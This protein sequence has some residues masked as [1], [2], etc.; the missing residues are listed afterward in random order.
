MTTLFGTLGAFLLLASLILSSPAFFLLGFALCGA[1]AAL[2]GVSDHSRGVESQKKVRA[3]RT[4]VRA[5]KKENSNQNW[6]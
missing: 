3:L 6:R 4:S 5:S 1:C 2:R